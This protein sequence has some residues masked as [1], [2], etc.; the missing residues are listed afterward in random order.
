MLTIALTGG[1]GS[2]KTAVTQLFHQIGNGHGLKIIDTDI[3]ARELLTGSY[4]EAPSRALKKVYELFGA[5][6]FDFSPQGGG[7]LDRAKLRAL[8]F[9]SETKKKQLE[10]LLH[11]LI[12]EEV[13]SQIKAFSQN[14]QGINIVI[15]AIPLLFET[16]TEN[17]FDRVLVIDVPVEVQIERSIQRDNCSRELIEQIIASQIDRQQRLARADD[18]I[19]NSGTLAH[20]GDQVEKLFRFYC[21]LQPPQ[22][23]FEKGGG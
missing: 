23:P 1:I 2:G 17:Q 11:P 6:L 8:I 22:S 13:F 10:A 16:H 14:K 19:D 9:S 4:N 7:Q 5:D 12:Y 20:L 18:V 3:I 21:S 15:I